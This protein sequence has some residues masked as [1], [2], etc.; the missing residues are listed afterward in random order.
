MWLG[1]GITV[2]RMDDLTARDLSLVE[3]AAKAWEEAN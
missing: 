1:A 2:L 3:A